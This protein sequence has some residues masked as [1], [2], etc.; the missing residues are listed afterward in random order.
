MNILVTGG[1]GFIG[2][3]FIRYWLKEHP[4]DDI[5]NYDKLTYAGNR[6]NLKDVEKKK[7]YKF[8][9]GDICD[10]FLVQKTLRKHNI[11]TIVHFA[12]ATHVDRSILESKKNRAAK[13]VVDLYTELL[14]TDFVLNNVWGTQ[15]LLEAAVKHG[16]KRFHHISTDEVFGHIPLDSKEKFSE[17]SPARPRSPYSASKAAAD[18]LVMAFHATYGLPVTISNCSNNFGPYHFPEKF[19]PLAITNL[20][21]GKKIPVYKPGNQIRDWLHVEDH[22][23]A[24]DLILQKGRIGETYCVGG[25]IEEISN[26]AVAKLITKILGKSEAD[27]ALVSDRPGHDV[28]YTIDWSK[29]KRELGWQPEHDFRQALEKTIDWYRSNGSW[30][31]PLKEKNREYFAKQYG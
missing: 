30:W 5:V 31:I 12:A 14:P 15:M 3:N 11:D 10:V 23:R 17:L 24:I 4:E 16:V 20:L 7:N 19:I 26:L 1:A 8:V 13:D 21:E 28:K 9:W 18:H 29:I 22:C 27:I 25:M 6:D 2:S